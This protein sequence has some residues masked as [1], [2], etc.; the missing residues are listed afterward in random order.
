[1]RSTQN[2]DWDPAK[3]FGAKVAQATREA[4][5]FAKLSETLASLRGSFLGPSWP[6][7]KNAKP[8]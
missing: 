7:I 6:E 8:G 3:P 5:K 1:M 2:I 4:E